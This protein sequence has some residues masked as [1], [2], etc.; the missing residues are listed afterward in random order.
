MRATFT[1]FAAKLAGEGFAFLHSRIHSVGP[2]L[3]A[4]RDGL[5]VGAIGPMETMPAPISKARMPQH[6]GILPE[7][8]GLGLG[9]LLWRA[10]MHWGSADGAD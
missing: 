2:V 1:A 10:A 3:T 8:R 7:Y 4:V 5:V 6:F 9:R